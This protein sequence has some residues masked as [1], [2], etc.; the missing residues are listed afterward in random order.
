LWRNVGVGQTAGHLVDNSWEMDDIV[1]LLRD[2]LLRSIL[3]MVALCVTIVLFFV[4]N[5]RLKRKALTYIPSVTRLLRVHESVMTGRVQILFD[6][7]PARAVSLVQITLINSGHEPIRTTDFE[8]PLRFQCGHNAQ[9]FTLDVVETEPTDLSPVVQLVSENDRPPS[10][11]E[12]QPL[13]LNKGDSLKIKALVNEVE[14]ETIAVHGRVV[15]VREIKRGRPNPTRAQVTLKLAFWALFISVIF[16]IYTRLWSSNHITEVSIVQ[17]KNAVEPGGQVLLSATV[18]S[19]PSDITVF[20]WSAEEGHF[21]PSSGLVTRYYAPD[22]P[23]ENPIVITIDVVTNDRPRFR[24]HSLIS[25]TRS[26]SPAKGLKKKQ[27]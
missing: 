24:T 16:L 20:H 13:L 27:P 19:R 14:M 18:I 11:F 4:A 21:S 9:I 5:W 25:V 17:D 8:R 6:G 3:A 26:T 10:E 12:L 23:R 15:G 22:E 2:P 7:A 1:T